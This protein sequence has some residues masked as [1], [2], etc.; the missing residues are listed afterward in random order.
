MSRKSAAAP[1]VYAAPPIDAGPELATLDQAGSIEAVDHIRRDTVRMLGAIE[2]IISDGSDRAADVQIQSLAKSLVSQV[3]QS[4]EESRAVD[5]RRRTTN[6]EKFY[7]I[8][9]LTMDVSTYSDRRCNW[10]YV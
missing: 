2:G 5:P 1:S 6:A 10:L 3:V 9:S 7:Q 8:M 4:T